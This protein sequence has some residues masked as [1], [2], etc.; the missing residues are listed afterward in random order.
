[1]SCS[2]PEEDS[3]AGISI[4]KHLDT[5]SVMVTKAPVSNS[6]ILM[7]HADGKLL[8]SA[9]LTLSQKIDKF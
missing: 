8:L 4:E 6:N 9:I 1:M 3:D 5:L 2:N 7:S